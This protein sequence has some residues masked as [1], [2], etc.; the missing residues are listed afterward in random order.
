MA[1]VPAERR[2]GFTLIELLVVIAIIA[3]L[4]SLLLPALGKWKF[5]G[6]ALIC[7]T[8]LKQFG[9]ATHSY[10]ADYQDKM[11]SFSWTPNS[12][13]FTTGSP[14]QDAGTSDLTATA[15]QARDIIWRRSGNDIGQQDAW[16]PHIL[17]THLVL[18]D[19]LAST[20]PNKS[21]V[22]PEDSVRLRWQT[23]VSQFIS[24]NPP[25]PSPAGATGRWPFSSSYQVPPHTFS[26]DGGPNAITPASGTHRGYTVPVTAE[27]YGKRKLG[28]VS[29]PSGKVQMF[30]GISRHTNGKR[31]YY[32]AY[33][34][35]KQP[36][37]MFDQ[38]VNT[39]RSGDANPGYNPTA[40]T[41]PSY[42]VVTY[43]P[44][45]AP[46]NWEPPTV[47]GNATDVFP[48]GRYQWT[49]AGMKG[50]DFG[51]SE[52]PWRGS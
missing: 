46:N 30:D 26:P 40:P 1:I 39:R 34:D 11:Y 28:D 22:C 32:Y 31:S 44:E 7:G 38:S 23:E 18:Q 48:G 17:Y 8:S 19:Y 42:L 50:I 4:I 36:L 16:I 47:S 29:F 2:Q 15:E 6:R 12:A 24:G 3:L 45:A 37:L 33:Q 5:T 9:V 52:V 25:L 10:A 13:R 51:G 27:I 35:G 41:S 21:V 43:A 20:L 14:V 49:R